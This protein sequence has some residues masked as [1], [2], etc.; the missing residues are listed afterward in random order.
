MR[1]QRTVRKRALSLGLLVLALGL[2][3]GVLTPAWPEEPKAL[4]A[5]Q[6]KRLQE[7]DRYE[8]QAQQ[9]IQAGKLD[10]LVAVWE[11]E[12]AIEREVLGDR[13]EQVVRSLQ[14]LAGL[15]EFREDF[16]AARK[17]RGQVL[18]ILTKLHGE[19][20]WRVT[21]A[22]LALEDTDLVA[23]L[24]GKNRRQLRQASGLNRQVVRPSGESRSRQVL[25]LAKKALEIRGQILGQRHRDYAQS[26][27]NLAGLYKDMGDHGSALPLYRQALEIWK[28]ALGE[29]H[30]DYATGL[31][32]LA[33]LYQAMGDSAK[34]E[35]LYRR[36]MEIRKET[37]G[38]KHPAYALSLNELGALYQGMGYY[39]RA[40]P[41]FRRALEIRKEVLGE[42]HPDYASSL[43]N[44]GLLYASKGDYA[45]ALP[46]Y[47]QALEI[48]KQALAV[49]YKLFP[50]SRTGAG[51]GRWLADVRIAGFSLV[52][53]QAALSVGRP[54]TD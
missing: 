13:H 46:L 6:Q 35:P 21:D 26:L 51:G 41:L 31:N 18:A 43:N 19:K 7:R 33:W 38:E 30:P 42:K 29:K 52:N 3:L 25:A 28:Q 37:L 8:Q 45:R 36:S 47:R 27:N 44:L 14:R 34:A 1:V 24:D 17:A 22:R 54:L 50:F 23:R 12:L 53:A 16:T 48:W 49:L 11:K 2:G 20:D 39:A 4:T 9:L 15:H 32:N 10:E 5:A 40:E